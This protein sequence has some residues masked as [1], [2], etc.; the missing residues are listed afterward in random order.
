M[1]HEP[2]RRKDRD[3]LVR[4][5][6]MRAKIAKSEIEGRKAELLAQVERQLAAKYSMGDER[7]REVTAA[8]DQAARDANLRI[9]QVFEEHGI[10]I[11]F[12][13]SMYVGWWDRGETA[14]AKRRDELRRVARAELDAKGKAAKLAIEKA[15]AETITELL[16]LT[17]AEEA[18][19]RLE[20]IP[21]AAELLVAP[22]VAELESAAEFSQRSQRGRL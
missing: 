1:N 3:D 8:A 19:G 17:M 6:K 4:I 18:K 12:A 2:L 21:S 5:A 15:E 11:E 9:Q 14:E 13:P 16:V 20:A 22:S 7:W 10:P